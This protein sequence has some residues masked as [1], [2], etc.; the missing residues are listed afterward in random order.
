MFEDVLA[1]AALPL[2]AAIVFTG[3]HTW[4]GLQVLRR[5]GEQ[6]G[7]LSLAVSRDN[8]RLASGGANTTSLVWGVPPLPA[9][10]VRAD[11][12]RPGDGV[13]PGKYAVLIS[14]VKAPRDPVSLIDE[15]YSVSA[16]TPYHETIEDD[17]DDLSY[18]VKMKDAAAN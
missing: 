8:R 17:V 16:T 18:A 12:R 10:V 3:I 2:A 13:L 1:F 15:Q 9:L 6:G 14:V 7:V 4:F 5:N 11:T